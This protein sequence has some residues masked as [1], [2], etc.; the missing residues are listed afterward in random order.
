MVT[1][2]ADMPGPS[3]VGALADPAGATFATM[4]FG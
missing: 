2:A 1:A 3:R 4:S